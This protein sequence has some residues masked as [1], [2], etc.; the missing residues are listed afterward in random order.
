MCLNTSDRIQSFSRSPNVPSKDLQSAHEAPAHQG[1]GLGA[2][3]SQDGTV[4]REGLCPP[5]VEQRVTHLEACLA[6]APEAGW[7]WTRVRHR[8]RMTDG[9][10]RGTHSKSPGEGRPKA[11]GG[12]VAGARPGAG[13]QEARGRCP[14]ASAVFTCRP[15]AVCRGV[16]F[17]EG[18]IHK[19][20][21]EHILVRTRVPRSQESS[22]AVGGVNSQSYSKLQGPPS[23]TQVTLRGP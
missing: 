23:A 22:F 20:L 8:P 5:Q 16:C 17:A 7:Q 6:G 9:W 2:H 3:T 13:T 19:E 10:Q 21:T 18:I 14:K 11:I 1:R 12:A 4:S 15:R